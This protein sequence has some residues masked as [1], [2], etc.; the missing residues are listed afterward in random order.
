ML[1]DAPNIEDIT[2]VLATRQIEQE[3]QTTVLKI[4][5]ELRQ[6]SV[7][8]VLLQLEAEKLNNFP[9]HLSAF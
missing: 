2:M 7:P 6:L 9:M 1:F 8:E 4:L 5:D 3:D